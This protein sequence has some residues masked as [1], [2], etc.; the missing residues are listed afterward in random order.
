M[1]LA[2]AMRHPDPSVTGTFVYDSPPDFTYGWRLGAAIAL[3]IL[4]TGR[5]DVAV[6]QAQPQSQR[7]P[8][9]TRGRRRSPAPSRR[10]SLARHR[11]A[12][13]CC[14]IRTRS[15]PRRCRWNRWR[16][17]PIASGQ[18]GLAALLQ[19]DPGGARD[20]PERPAGGARLS[21]RAR[22]SRARHRDATEMRLRL[23]AASL[24]AAVADVRLR[25]SSQSRR[26]RRPPPP[27]SA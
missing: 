10:P 24:A 23:A 13:P 3:P 1:A 25:Q 19:T 18:T 20:A 22:G 6:A 16:T 8:I 14:A 26:S 17:N 5:A 9:A 21:A 7:S 2:Q 4:T 11:R 27:P 15:C 12:R